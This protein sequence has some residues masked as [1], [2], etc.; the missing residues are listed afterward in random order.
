M[1]HIYDMK[2]VRR[3]VQTKYDYHK[4]VENV[5]FMHL[6]Q[7]ELQFVIFSHHE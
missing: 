6:T 5:T 4:C 3:Y 2:E 1:I 7:K